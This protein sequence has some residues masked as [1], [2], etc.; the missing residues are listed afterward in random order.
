MV[1]FRWKQVSQRIERNC[2]TRFFRSSASLKIMHFSPKPSLFFLEHTKNT[3]S[4]MITFTDD[5]LR[6]N[7]IFG[8]SSS[9][10]DDAF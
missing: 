6:L 10:Q 3:I 1:Y 4:T 2:V 5:D 9:Q 7:V 8:F